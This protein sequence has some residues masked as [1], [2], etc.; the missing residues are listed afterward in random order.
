[1]VPLEISTA[2]SL[3]IDHTH[4]NMTEIHGVMYFIMEGFNP[5]M[6]YGL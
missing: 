2:G 1:M 4:Q 6:M 3:K 5:V